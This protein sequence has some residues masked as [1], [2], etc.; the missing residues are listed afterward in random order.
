[1]LLVCSSLS[2]VT[3]EFLIL[4]VFP[5][6]RRALCRRRGSVERFGR[7]A[8]LVGSLECGLRGSVL[9]LEFFQLFGALGC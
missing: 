9:G 2:C 5:F 7:G 6:R 4:A 8:V 3:L 1:M